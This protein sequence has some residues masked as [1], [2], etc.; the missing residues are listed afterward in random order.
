MLN[1]EQVRQHHL[2]QKVKRPSPARGSKVLVAGFAGIILVGT[3]LL[4]LPLATEAAGSLT[5]M[6]AM[7]TATSATTVTGLTV[8]STETTFS[9]FGEIVILILI[10]IGGIGFITLSVVLFQLIGR[11]VTLY[12]RT[13][14]T[15][16]LGVGGRR[17]VVRLTF[18]VFIITV[19]IELIGAIFLFSQWV[20]VMDWR[21]AAYYAIFHAISSYCNAGFDLFHGLDDPLLHATRDNVITVMT[22]AMLITVGTLGITVIYD[23]MVWSR[24]RQLSL[25]TRLVVP[26]TIFLTLLGTLLVVIDESFVEGHALANFPLWE[27]W[28]LAFFTI[29][30][31]RTAGLTLIPMNDLGEASQLIILVWMF[32][33][34]APA[35]MAGGVGLSTVAVVMITL[36][37]TAR[38]YNDARVFERTIPLETIFKAVA[39]LTVSTMHVAVATLIMLFFAEG[40]L[41]PIGFE[42]VS[43]FSNT[44]YSLGITSELGPVGRILIAFTMFWGRLGPLTL[45]VALAQRR[46]QT[47]I[48]YPEEKI[49]IG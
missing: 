42:V 49:L 40:D 8:V 29:V 7:F 32:I 21:K 19:A 22:M 43:A 25:Y 44:G 24:S 31:S 36:L 13:M 6:E 4:K 15:Q 14:L 2:E 34:G 37:A 18:M 41:F 48:Q 26:M 17:G 3:L 9:L 11:R 12:E 38:G 46:R 39:V 28:V 33:G 47:L 23:L 27:R 5:W 20:H 35:S 30:S 10:Q 16:A 1:Y 45:V